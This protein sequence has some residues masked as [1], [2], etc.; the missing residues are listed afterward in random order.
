V[1]GGLSALVSHE[2]KDRESESCTL[3][4]P[5]PPAPMV[6]VGRRALVAVQ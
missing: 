5:A 6:G 2:F 4:R 3:A 1:G